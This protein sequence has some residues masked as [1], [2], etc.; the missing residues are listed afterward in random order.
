MPVTAE[1]H[2]A[3]IRRIVIAQSLYA[4]GAVLCFFNTWGIAAILLVQVNY[5][6]AQDSAG[7]SSRRTTGVAGV[8]KMDESTTKGW[9]FHGSSG[10]TNKD[11]I[12]WWETRR[13][14][15]NLHV[16]LTGFGT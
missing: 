3:V 5:A 9:L 10:T 12:R 11:I 6:I 8:W 14:H 13:L 7:D 4:S 15:F 16:G 2:P 1:F